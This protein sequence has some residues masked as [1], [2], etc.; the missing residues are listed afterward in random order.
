MAVAVQVESRG[1]SARRAIWRMFV[2]L[3]A[4]TCLGIVLD[5]LTT[6]LGYRQDGSAYEQNPIGAALIQHLGWFGLAGVMAIFAA[7]L[8]FSFRTIC[9]RLSAK[10][11]VF[12]VVILFLSA[13]VRWLAVVTAIM[14]I[15]RFM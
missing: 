12:F 3:Y 1:F 14:Y 15:S 7:I 11:T 2:P 10:V 6:A 9:F 13:I 5:I 8:F 4:A